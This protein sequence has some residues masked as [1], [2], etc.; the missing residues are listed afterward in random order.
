MPSVYKLPADIIAS[1][2]GYTHKVTITSGDLTSTTTAQTITLLS[3]PAG[4]RVASVAERVKTGFAHATATTFTSVV[5]V[6]GSTAAHLASHSLT[7]S[8]GADSAKAAATNV[9]YTSATNLIATISLDASSLSA[10]TAGSV[11]YYVQLSDL[12]NI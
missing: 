3:I 7:S 10:T 12:D 6:A 5:G 11:D 8:T 1:Q 9:A 2:G 4:G